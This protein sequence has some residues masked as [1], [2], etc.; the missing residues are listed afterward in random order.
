MAVAVLGGLVASGIVSFFLVPCLYAYLDDLQRAINAAIS[1]LRAR[2]HRA[3]RSKDPGHEQ[4]V[5]AADTA[6]EEASLVGW[7]QKR[8]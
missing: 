7:A 2:R 8:E 6:A 1:S 4:L 5:P 3:A